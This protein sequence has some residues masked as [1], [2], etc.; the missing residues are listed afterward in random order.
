[1]NELNARLQKLVLL[2]SVEQ[3]KFRKPVRPGDHIAVKI[4]V[5]LRIAPRLAQQNAR[6]AAKSGLRRG[7]SPAV[8]GA[9]QSRYP[10][11]DPA[12]GLPP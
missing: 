2:A 8:A 6:S 12:K 11:P 1:M 7:N 9:G 10:C 3:A 5:D 4:V